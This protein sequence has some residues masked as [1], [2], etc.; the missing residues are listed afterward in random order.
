MGEMLVVGKYFM[1][2]GLIL[3]CVVE[4]YIGEEFGFGGNDVGCIIFYVLDIFFWLKFYFSSGFNQLVW[5]GFVIGCVVFVYYYIEQIGLGVG[6]NGFDFVFEKFMIV[7]GNYV[8]FKVD[9]V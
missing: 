5:M 4:K 3:L 9:G 2:L 6:F 1:Q 7:I 8:Y